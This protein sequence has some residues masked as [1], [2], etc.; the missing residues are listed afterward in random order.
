MPDWAY[1][2]VGEDESHADIKRRDLGDGTYASSVVN[3]G[4]AS[5]AAS[6]TSYSNGTFTTLVSSVNSHLSGSTGR[7]ISVQYLSDGTL[8]PTFYA[9]ITEQS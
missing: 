9:I 5:S 8:T 2:E 7:L 1:T 6:C 4:I 3:E